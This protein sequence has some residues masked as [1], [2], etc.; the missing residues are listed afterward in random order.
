[1]LREFYEAH[2]NERDRFELVSICT[3]LDPKMQTMADFDRMLQPIKKGVWH[4]KELPFP[5]LLDNT[6]Q[7]MENFGVDL[8]GITL[9][10]DPTGALSK[11]MKRPLRSS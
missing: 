3:D 5:V 1:M 11:A 7:S 2:K 6:S 9:L 4:G 8:Y 10:M